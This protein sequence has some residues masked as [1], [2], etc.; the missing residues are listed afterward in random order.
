M[1]RIDN[2]YAT[3]KSYVKFH[4]KIKFCTS[5]FRVGGGRKGR[6]SERQVPSLARVLTGVALTNNDYHIKSTAYK[7]YQ[8][9]LNTNIVLA[10]LLYICYHRKHVC[11][12]TYSSGCRKT[13]QISIK[14]YKILT[15]CTDTIG[16]ASGT[17]RFSV[18][19]IILL[20]T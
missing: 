19:I 2:D 5:K 11:T 10:L 16:L 4:V 13:I 14:R 18:G 12:F 6:R 7:T 1:R 9:P 3:S 20:Y 15:T 8:I 17:S